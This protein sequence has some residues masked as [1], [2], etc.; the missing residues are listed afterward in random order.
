MRHPER[1][2]HLVLLGS[3]A[4]GR[5]ARAKTPEEGELAEARIDLVRLGWGR[6]TRRTGRCSWPVSCPTA[7]RSSGALRR[8]AAPLDSAENAWRF[9]DEFANID[10]TELA[11][12]V[13]TPTLILCSRREPDNVFE[14]SRL[15]AGLIPGSRLVPLDSANH[16]LPEQDP[17]WRQFL[18][19]ID[20][21][22]GRG[23]RT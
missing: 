9:L 11:P 15:L 1:V 4:Q 10:V 23:P 8:A 6:P 12:Q 19:E 22:I 16:L 7:L 2:S 5:R 18:A 17:A 21:F 3:F 20:A 13:T 14:Q